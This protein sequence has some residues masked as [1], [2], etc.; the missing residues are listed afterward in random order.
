[1]RACPANL[2]SIEVGAERP[3]RRPESRHAGEDAR[4]GQARDARQGLPAR[5]R[6]QQGHAGVPA[7]HLQRA[8]PAARPGRGRLARPSR[9]TYNDD[10]INGWVGIG[11]QL[12]G[13]GH[14]GIDGVYY[15]CNRAA[16]FAQADGLRKLGTE[17]VPAIATRGVVLDMAGYLNTEIVN[18]GT[19]FNREEIEGAMKR[20]GLKAIERGDVVL[21]YTG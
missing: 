4:G 14:I 13:L 6:D 16:D 3:D 1:Q 17:N 7:A 20:Q 19:V 9:P 18:E 5:H 11:S 10:I 15:N 12:D 21:F 8:R 2:L